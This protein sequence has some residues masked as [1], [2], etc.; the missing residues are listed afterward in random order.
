MMSE[1]A[2]IPP[3]ALDLEQAILGAVMI[4]KESLDEVIGVLSPDDFY[5]ESHRIIYEAILD[6][7]RD[8]KQIDIL[9]V[10]ESL[11]KTKKLTKAGG[12]LYITQ[13]TGKVATAQHIQEHVLIVKEKSL[14]RQLIAFGNNLIRS[15]Y[16]PEDIEDLIILANHDF[17]EIIKALYGATGV[18]SFKNLLKDSLEEAEQRQKLAAKG[19]QTGINTPLVDLTKLTGGFQPGELII[20]AGRPSMGKSSFALAACKKAAQEKK[21]VLFFSLEMK[22]VRLTDRILIGETD[23][24][25]E[26]FKTGKIGEGDWVQLEKGRGNLQDLGIYI[27]DSPLINIDYIRAKSRVMSKKR[28]CDMII[29]DYLGLIDSK[30]NKNKIREQEVAE[31][32]RRT[33][34]L[35]MELDIPVIL[36]SQLNRSCELRSDKRPQLSDLR[37]SGAIEQ[38]ADIVAFL[39]R[40][41]Y[42]GLNDDQ[43]YKVKGIGEVIIAKNRNGRT[44]S[45]KFKHNK[46]MTNIYDMPRPGEEDKE[47]ID[48]LDFKT[49]QFNDP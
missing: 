48:S 7:D 49:R 2:K 46:A 1:Q 3:Q 22:S 12:S 34:L 6:L 14:Q 44:G 8:E 21:H 18:I 33:K 43:G 26:D 41:E 20:F 10:T 27:F 25:P 11:E 35:A 28:Q 30:D 9:T 31:I 29:I 4:E 17:E 47:P 16:D 13:L 42:Y 38:D 32:S 19:E 37:E 24:E 23:M 40:P 5:K 39:Y 15:S 36:L 45:I